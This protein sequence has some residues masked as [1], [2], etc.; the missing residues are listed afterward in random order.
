[1]KRGMTIIELI[2]AITLFVTVITLV[3]GSF[4]SIS[5][6]KLL[7]GSMKE[8]QNKIRLISEMITRFGKEADK[9]K[10][11]DNGSSVDFW[12]YKKNSA[13]VTQSVTAKKF[14]LSAE[15]ES[16]VY[17]NCQTNAGTITNPVFNNTDCAKEELLNVTD[18]GYKYKVL[19]RTG[20]NTYNIFSKRNTIPPT[21]DVNL[22]LLN[23]TT[24]NSHFNDSIE[25]S[26]IIILENIK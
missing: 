12:F 19:D 17:Y 25:L 24:T 22:K 9:A 5:R 2:V 18:L 1:M 6:T 21:L 13:G 8:S 26:N 3:L 23:I 14:V 10:V 4:V 20:A 11:Y 15:G 16:L 7:V